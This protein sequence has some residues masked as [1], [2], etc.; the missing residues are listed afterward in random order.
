MWE[1][2]NSKPIY[3]QIIDR[4]KLDIISGHYKPGDKLPSVRE[5][6]SEAAVNPNTMQ[7]ALSLL[8][9]TE[10]IYANRTSGRYITEDISQIEELKCELAAQYCNDFIQ[11]VRHIGLDNDAI[12]DI[13]KK[14]LEN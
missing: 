4:I 1:M 11:N 3:M 8:E 12:F 7:K 13:L 10:L 2:N 5:L 14:H 6:A 9:T